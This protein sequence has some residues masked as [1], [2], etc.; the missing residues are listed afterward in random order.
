[1]TPEQALSVAIRTDDSD[2]IEIDRVHARRMKDRRTYRDDRIARLAAVTLCDSNDH[3]RT[4]RACD[5]C[6]TAIREL[7]S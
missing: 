6:R 3:G 5:S 2:T 4:V 7:M 1:M